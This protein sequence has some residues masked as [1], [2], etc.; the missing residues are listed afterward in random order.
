M[1]TLEGPGQN[2][3]CVILVTFCLRLNLCP[4]EQMTEYIFEWINTFKS[5]NK[6]KFEDFPGMMNKIRPYNYGLYI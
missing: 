3:D 6:I 4:N 5:K 2:I 1:L